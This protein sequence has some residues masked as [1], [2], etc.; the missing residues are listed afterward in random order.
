MPQRRQ[1]RDGR[2]VSAEAGKWTA[3][4]TEWFKTLEEEGCDG[5]RCSKEAGK[6]ETLTPHSVWQ[7]EAAEVG[8]QWTG[9]RMEGE[10]SEDGEERLLS[11]WEGEDRGGWWA[12]GRQGEEWT[13]L[14]S[15]EG[16]RSFC[17]IVF[18]FVGLFDN[19]EPLTCLWAEGKERV[20]GKE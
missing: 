13:R 10:R 14:N 11:G 7:W 12:G 17:L 15:I 19:E 2:E 16:T 4:D 8:W 9:K 18:C 5:F 3:T 20:A 6:T 1:R